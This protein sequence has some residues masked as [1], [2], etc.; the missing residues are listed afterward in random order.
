MAQMRQEQP[1]NC[2]S[3]V[4]AAL[5]RKHCLLDLSGE[6][7]QDAISSRAQ[8]SWRRGPS[9]SAKSARR[10]IGRSLGVI[11]LFSAG[12]VWQLLPATSAAGGQQ[13]PSFDGGDA[14]RQLSSTP[15]SEKHADD[16]H[17][18]DVAKDATVA[19]EESAGVWRWLPRGRRLGKGQLV[20]VDSSQLRTSGC[21]SGDV[22]L[23]EGKE[24]MIVI[25]LFGILYMFVALAIVCDEF[26]VPALETFVDAY[27]I[28]MDVAGA[29]FMAAG[30]SMPELCTSFIGTF[31]KS[32]VGFSTIVGSA[33]FNVLLV[34]GVC[35][36]F[37]REV[38]CLTWWPL[39]RDIVY[40]IFT[41]SSLAIFFSGFSKSQI[42]WWEALIL[43][44]EY[45]GYC[46]VMKFNEQ[47]W[48]KVQSL[49]GSSPVSPT[50]ENAA[51]D[52]QKLFCKPSLFRRGIIEILKSNQDIAD[53]VGIAAITQI[54]GNVE[55]TFRQI[56]RDDNG[57]LD[58]T[59]LGSLLE[60]IGAK[61][62]HEHVVQAAKHIARN[63]NG[64]I[65]FDDFSKW[66]MGS[67]VRMEVSTRRVFD[68]FDVDG[69][70]YVDKQEVKGM[71]KSL[72]HLLNETQVDEIVR[73]I[74]GSTSSNGDG[75][76]PVMTTATACDGHI[77]FEQFEAWYHKSMFW[78]RQLDK[79]QHEEPETFE[80]D[81]PD[82]PRARALFM[83]LFTYPI[84]AALY[85]TM[86]D[87]RRKHK[88]G[89]EIL[90][91]YGQFLMSL[92]W[93]ITFAWCLVDWVTLLSNSIGV[94]VPVAAVTILAAGTSIPDLLS[95]YIVARQGEGDMAVSSS[96]GSNIFDVCFGLPVPWLAFI[97]SG[98]GNV[99]V[100]SDSIGFWVIILLIMILMV[101][102]TI[103]I[104]KWRMTKPMG[105]A[106]LV[107]Y[108]IFVI[109]CILMEM[110]EGDPKIPP[111]DF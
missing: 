32:D 69:S 25:Y 75:Q 35:A 18:A 110:P 22:C 15:S 79:I 86:P 36:I 84:C 101:V 66:Y 61:H 9:I 109:L 16:A 17:V 58:V 29:T 33:V 51:G 62:D 88:E 68:Q 8:A 92:L 40:Y 74:Q 105:F 43:F 54:K 64:Q 5:D 20:M 56:D 96:I 12:A 55:A 57:F 4:Q 50:A 89:R 41:L 106:M 85:I 11:L 63:G 46:I 99:K 2:H 83:Y 31:T 90:V 3:A 71:M 1:P 48:A 100:E 67:E 72:G 49:T 73:E 104:A 6:H 10:I 27:G 30:G 42:E 37:S 52:D 87:V 94:P 93:I 78:D 26:F 98:N 81:W 80:I 19:A 95:S 59:E 28:S 76:F 44:L 47:I 13:L 24:W 14:H 7:I 82:D 107:L 108:L 111:P 53:T 60:A 38:L 91:A 102:L 103:M 34:I 23:D 21:T 65:T 77:Y 70:G 39:F 45:L 97:I